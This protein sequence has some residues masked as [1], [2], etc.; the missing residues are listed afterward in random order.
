MGSQS[1]M[2]NRAASPQQPNGP[3]YGIG[4]LKSGVPTIPWN[5]TV[6]ALDPATLNVSVVAQVPLPWGIEAT[7]NVAIGPSFTAD[8]PTG[9][10][11]IFWMA[12]PARDVPGNF[13]LL[14][15]SLADGS[16]VTVSAEPLCTPQGFPPTCPY[17]LHWMP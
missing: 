11:S 15:T 7:A 4:A 12:T 10:E 14:Q 9:G 8:G 5:R 1:V 13:Y 17:A 2:W 6:D 3:L 16:V